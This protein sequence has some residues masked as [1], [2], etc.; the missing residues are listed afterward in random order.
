MARTGIATFHQV[1]TLL[2]RAKTRMARKFTATKTAIR[3]MVKMKPVPVTLL[4]LVLYRAG[5]KW[6]AYSMNA[7]HSIG[8]IVTACR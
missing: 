7:K 1:S 6:A 2:T 3:M 4:V 8:A 5:Q